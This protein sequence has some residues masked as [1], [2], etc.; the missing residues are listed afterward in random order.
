MSSKLQVPCITLLGIGTI[1]GCVIQMITDYF[2]LEELIVVDRV[3]NLDS[4]VKELCETTRFKDQLREINITTQQVELNELNY[5]ERLAP[6]FARS[7]A[8]LDLTT[9]VSTTALA[10]LAD[11]FGCVY[12]NACIELFTKCTTSIQERHEECRKLN[13]KHT[14]V[15]EHGMNPGIV[16]HLLKMGL[17]DSGLTPSDL[18]VVHITEYDE[19][20]L[21]QE[22]KKPDTFYNTWSPFGLYEEAVERAELA[23]PILKALPPPFSGCVERRAQMLIFG[24]HSGYEVYLDS[25]TP[26]ITDSGLFVGWRPYQGYVITHGE[27]E[28]ISS[29]LGH[30]I[31][32]AFV[33]RTSPDATESLFRWGKEQ[34]PRYVMM[35]GRDIEKGGDTIGVLLR[36]PSKKKAW[37]IGSYQTNSAAQKIVSPVQNGATV[38]VASGCLAALVWAL[39]H[40]NQG[41]VFPEDLDT[42]EIWNLTKKYLG[43]V[44]SREVPWNLVANLNTNPQIGTPVVF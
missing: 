4:R 32:C 11:E 38:T 24:D 39:R 16:S 44:E 42:T 35:E 21:F 20:L 23:W 37:W 18:D 41:I 19:H 3:P 36:S 7:V 17:V 9:V 6:L 22:K 10:T 28:T 25:V 1:G 14:I 5:K 2:F 34:A 15:L 40:P 12:V 13:P 43:Y 26:V 30:N 27:T 8:V 31:I 33:F 29:F